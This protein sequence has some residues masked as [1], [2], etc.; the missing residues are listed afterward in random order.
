MW[1]IGCRASSVDVILYTSDIDTAVSEVVTVPIMATFSMMGKDEKGLLPQAIKIIDPY[2][3]KNSKVNI[4]KGN[5]GD[6]LLVI[7]TTMPIG[8]FD[9]LTNYQKPF[10]VYAELVVNKDTSKSLYLVHTSTYKKLNREL[11]KL[12][13][14][15]SL[16]FPAKRTNIRI[17]S[18]SKEE[19]MVRARSTWISKKPELD[20]RKKLNKREEIEFVFKG[21]GD[22][23]YSVIDPCVHM[24]ETD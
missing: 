3:A 11:R 8:T 1:F 17:I 5:Y 24:W 7:E 19:K 14:M 16:D 18:D 15:L 23:V 9:N 4:V 20:F 6:M 10:L 21:R 13:R 12:N 2:L 22:S